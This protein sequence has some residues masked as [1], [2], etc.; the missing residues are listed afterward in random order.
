MGRRIEF[1]YY[2]SVAIGLAIANASFTITAQLFTLA[3]TA[4]VV[5][6]IL[7]A[8]GL[9]FLVAQ[10]VGELASALPTAPG[11]RAYLY[12]AWGDGLSGFATYVYLCFV[13]L[14]AALETLLFGMVLHQLFPGVRI[15]L[16]AVAVIS[17]TATINLLGLSP[18]RWVQLVCSSMLAVALL[19][20]GTWAVVVGLTAP[21]ASVTEVA[22][23]AS[24][25]GSGAHLVT[26]A[27]ATGMALFLMVGFEWITP[28][29]FRAESY[30]SLIPKAMTW[31][32]VANVLL[33]TVF[34]LGLGLALGRAG[35]SSS[36]IP[37]MALSNQLFASAGLWLAMALSALSIISTFNAGLSGGARL[38]YLLSREKKLPRVLSKV[39]L[40]TGAPVAAILALSASA[41]VGAVVL[42]H[43]KL[44]IVAAICGS[45]IVCFIYAA[46]VSAAVKLRNDPVFVNRAYRASTSLW[47][48]AIVV[49]L[50][51]AIGALALVDDP[52][53]GIQPLI[54]CGLVIA[55]ALGLHFAFG[56][57]AAK[58]GARLAAAARP[59]PVAVPASGVEEPNR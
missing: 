32:V 43:L 10:T 56:R 8:G 52:H 42:I 27:K 45:A 30:R 39:S 23:T 57:R 46:L 5:A 31:S 49:P 20:L 25:T 48:R 7:V 17:L 35:A 36:L 37:H 41:L 24:S 54:A 40:R 55:M 4:T 2:L 12:R 51:V 15:E 38:V 3:D 16:V 29:G 58:P 44:E 18:P 9:L 1:V 28:L 14:V 19:G 6:A 50:L 34:A 21:P 26:V 22:A 13:I 53:F 59:A 33:N 11:V 47:F